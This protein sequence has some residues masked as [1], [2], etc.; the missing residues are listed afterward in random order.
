MAGHPIFILSIT[1]AA[2]HQRIGVP[3]YRK[4]VDQKLDTAGE[5]TGL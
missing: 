1:A 4:P 5:C 3:D 2:N